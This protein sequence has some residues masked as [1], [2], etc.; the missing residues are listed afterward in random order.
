MTKLVHLMDKP[1]KS[2]ATIQAWVFTPRARSQLHRYNVNQI[3]PIIHEGASMTFKGFI[4]SQLPAKGCIGSVM[5]R[6]EQLFIGQ[7]PTG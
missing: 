7:L 2:H 5:L 1:F 6:L 4:Y 3:S